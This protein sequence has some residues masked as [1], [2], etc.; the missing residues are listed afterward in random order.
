[1]PIAH[2]VYAIVSSIFCALLDAV[3]R[4]RALMVVMSPC[5]W[6]RLSLSLSLSW[7]LQWRHSVCIRRTESVCQ[8]R[9][10]TTGSCENKYL[11]SIQ[12]TAIECGF[13]CVNYVQI[14]I[15]CAGFWYFQKG[16]NR[17][18][19]MFSFNLFHDGL[20]KWYSAWWFGSLEWSLIL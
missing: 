12:K 1:M 10:A 5:V 15:K 8:V 7:R 18:Y 11:I 14:Y 19:K 20:L 4:T 9:H 3:D 17:T 13:D 2:S 16:I 6:E